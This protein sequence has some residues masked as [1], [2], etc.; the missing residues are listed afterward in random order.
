MNRIFSVILAV[1]MVISV[2]GCAASTE[3]IKFEVDEDGSFIYHIVRPAKGTNSKKVDAAKA[4]RSGIIENLGIKDVKLHDDHI[5][6]PS[7]YEILVGETNREESAQALGRLKENRVNCSSDFIVKVIG[8]KICIV[9][10]ND[11]MLGVACD[12]FAATFCSSVENWSKL[13]A[14]YEFIYAPNIVNGGEE[15]TVNTVSNADLGTFNIAIPQQTTLIASHHAKFI[16]DYYNALGYSVETYRAGEKQTDYEILLGDCDREESKSVT[17]E[18]DNFV[19]KVVGKKIVVKGGSDLATYA[20]GERLLAEIKKAKDGQGFNWSDGYVLNGKYEETEE[21]YKLTFGDEFNGS[22]I[23]YANWGH[24]PGYDFKMGASSLG[25]TMYRYRGPVDDEAIKDFKGVSTPIYVSDGS[26]VFTAQRFNENDFLSTQLSTYN[27]MIY[28]YG[29]IE[30]R[31]KVGESPS[32]VSYW[33]NGGLTERPYFVNRFGSEVVREA[34]TEVDIVENFGATHEFASNV[35]VWWQRYDK[36]GNSAGLG[37]TSLDG[38]ENY[39]GASANNKKYV[40]NHV[41]ANDYHIF[42]MYWDEECIQFAFDG[43]VYLDYQYKDN[44]SSSVHRLMNYFIFGLSLGNPSYGWSYR[45]GEHKDLYEHKVD[46]VRI[47]QSESKNS[48]MIKAWPEAQESGTRTVVFP[49]NPI[50]LS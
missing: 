3:G 39:T 40:N 34:Q 7:G 14:D 49:D 48:Q 2:S 25:G 28:R 45:K 17:V 15:V 30:I 22:T 9:A 27:N 44:M 33:V 37:H 46:Y 29:Y 43:K 11:E 4:V 20:A 6:T 21:A 42:S 13:R 31:G 8:K 12:W 18:G 26:I 36:N 24:Y 16:Q 10:T 47:Y 38:N 19:I 32:T 41:I 35:H 50:A 5:E 23:N 1:L